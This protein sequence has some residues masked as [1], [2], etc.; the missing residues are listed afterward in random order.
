M[1]VKFL[2]K[3]FRSSSL[4]GAKR[5]ILSI[6]SF[7]FFLLNQSIAPLALLALCEHVCYAST[8]LQDPLSCEIDPD[9]WF[10]ESSKNISLAKDLCSECP[11]RDRCI[12]LAV[13][14]NEVHGIWGGINFADPI[15]RK[16][17]PLVLCR[18]KLH[19]RSRGENC[20]E[21]RK[22]SQRTYYLNNRTKINNKR[23]DRRKP[24]PRKH[25]EGGY[26]VN[27]HHLT[28]DNIIIRKSDGS[29]M[30]K[31]CTRNFKAGS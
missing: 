9:F 18:K 29:I 6:I 15:E 31:K 17:S 16:S 4:P 1:L 20:D 26:C 25:V 22:I 12:E 28:K 14:N 30:C 10:S 24:E 13:S 21:C 23:N 19:I 8:M 5:L 11:L 7:D 2:A 3:I 27:E